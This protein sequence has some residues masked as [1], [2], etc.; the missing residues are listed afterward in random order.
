[1]RLIRTALA[2]ATVLAAGA[3][4]HAETA[5]L[6]FHA[7]WCGKCQDLAPKLAEAAPAFDAAGVELIKLDFT[8]RSDEARAA[9]RDIAAEAGLLA[10]YEQHAPR[11]GFVLLVDTETGET[12][13]KIK[14]SMST[15][16]IE[17]KLAKV[18][19]AS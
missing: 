9:Q 18:S 13:G 2:A 17:T 3:F 11:T 1:M 8:D 7:D 10:V 15:A 6:Q 4:A 19:A 16:E 5:A 12:L 14:A